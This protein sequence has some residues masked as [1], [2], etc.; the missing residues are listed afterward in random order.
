MG[1]N[2]LYEDYIKYGKLYNKHAAHDCKENK[3]DIFD[4]HYI[5]AVYSY[6]S[7]VLDI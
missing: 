3:C 2:K 1:M 6:I 4:V 5:Q 7:E